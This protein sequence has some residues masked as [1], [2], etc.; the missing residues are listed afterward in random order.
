MSRLPL[1]GQTLKDLCAAVK[2]IGQ[3]R[4]HNARLAI[5]TCPLSER[6]KREGFYRDP[7]EMGLRELEPPMGAGVNY[8]RSGSWYE[9]EEDGWT[10][11]ETA[12]ISHLSYDCQVAPGVTPTS[13]TMDLLL[14]SRHSR[15]QLTASFLKAEAGGH[16]ADTWFQRWKVT[17]LV[18]WPRANDHMYYQSGEVVAQAGKPMLIKCHEGKTLLWC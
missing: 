10:W 6:E 16:I 7:Q 3:M 17:E 13:G 9:I 12:N 8:A 11:C 18:L 14:S 2:V 15:Y 5:R 4:P 1:G